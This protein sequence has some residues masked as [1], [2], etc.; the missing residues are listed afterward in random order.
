M[1]LG[2][3]FWILVLL[4]LAFHLWS[5]QPS[6]PPALRPFSWVLVL[7]LFILLGWQVFGPALHR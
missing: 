4:T 5:A 1:T 7:L 3:L 2:L 6:S